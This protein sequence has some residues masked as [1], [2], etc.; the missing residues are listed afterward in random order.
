MAKK[1]I[2]GMFDDVFG[3]KSVKEAKKLYRKRGA[4]GYRA[5]RGVQA[6]GQTSGF[7]YALPEKERK[8]IRTRRAKTTNKII[9]SMKKKLFW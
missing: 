7:Y 1:K 5:R 2:K 9:K 3:G 6:V 4:S 8:K